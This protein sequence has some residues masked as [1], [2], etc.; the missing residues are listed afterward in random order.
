MLESFVRVKANACKACLPSNV[1]EYQA[2]GYI[3]LF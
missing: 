1:L 3:S 2:L